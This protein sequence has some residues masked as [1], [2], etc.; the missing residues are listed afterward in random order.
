MTDITT[1]TSTD[2]WHDDLGTPENPKSEREAAFWKYHDENPDIYDGFDRFARDVVRSNRDTFGAQ[3]I[4]ERLR[5][6]MAIERDEDSFKVNNN[7]SGYY[8]RLWM[9]NNPTQRGLFRRRRLR[10]QHAPTVNSPADLAYL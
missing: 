10:A 3:A 8:A 6:F 7:Y 4:F 1:D 5:W 2:A 9:R